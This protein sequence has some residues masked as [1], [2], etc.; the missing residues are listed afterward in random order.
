MRVVPILIVASALMASCA[1]ALTRDEENNVD[2]YRR[3]NAGVVNITSR[4]VSYDFFFNPIPTDSSGSGVILDTQGHVL[5]NYHVVKGAQRLE[6]SLAD[7]TKWPAKVLGADPHTDLAVLAIKAP[8]ESLTIM[9]LGDS[10]SLQV[11]QKVLAIGNPF[12]LE[13]SLSSGIISMIRKVV[14]AGEIEIEDV[15]QTDAAINPGNSGGPLLNSEGKV[16]GINTAIFTPSGGNVG[17]GF[18][19]PINTAKRV[20]GDILTH[21][22]VVYPYFGA[23]TQT[24]TALIAR[25]LQLPVDRGVL[26]VRVSKGSPAARAGLLSGNQQVII[27]NTIVVVGG[28]VI[29]GADGQPLSTAEELRRLLR[30]HMPDDIIRLDIIRQGKRAFL[31]VRLGERPREGAVLR[32]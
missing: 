22:F 5:T 13:H 21:G 8:P 32:E 27:G 11:G 18:A 31:D 30:H 7:R 6:V 2:I 9:P 19:I 25:T 3:F 28:D 26:V 23:E 17:I 10:S 24:L 15:I 1:W 14:K 12:G 16:V 20:V 29:I 4:A